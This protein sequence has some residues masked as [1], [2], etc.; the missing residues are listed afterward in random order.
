MLHHQLLSSPPLQIPWTPLSIIVITTIIRSISLYHNHQWTHIPII[1]VFIITIIDTTTIN[2]IYITIIIITVT[3]TYRLL[4][5]LVS[6]ITTNN[7]HHH[8]HHNHYTYYN[9]PLPSTPS[10]PTTNNLHPEL[11]VGNQKFHLLIGMIPVLP[12]WIHHH[13][14][15]HVDQHLLLVLSEQVIFLELS[16]SIKQQ[17]VYTVCSV[18][19]VG[20]QHG[21]LM[22]WACCWNTVS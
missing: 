11:K 18:L 13:L 4:S 16:D 9:H 7:L 21:L 1:T 17:N 15:I 6:T 20:I 19:Y 12:K 8:H 22:P 3:T 14:D 10:S 5:L 2:S